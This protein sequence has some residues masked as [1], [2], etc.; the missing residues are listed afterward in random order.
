MKNTIVVIMTVL[1]A[2]TIVTPAFADDGST[3][4]ACTV[5]D[6]FFKRLF[7]LCVDLDKSQNTATQT[8]DT[9]A[10]T[11]TESNP[12]HDNSWKGICTAYW[13]SPEAM[14]NPDYKTVC[15]SAPYNPNK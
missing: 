14:R 2:L 13:M 15:E 10:E 11:M 7:G 4:P 6:G 12:V 5:N 3:K 1:I 9:V 8:G